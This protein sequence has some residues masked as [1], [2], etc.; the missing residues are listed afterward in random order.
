[1]LGAAGRRLSRRFEVEICDPLD[2]VAGKPVTT[3]FTLD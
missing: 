3:G 2:E 1:M